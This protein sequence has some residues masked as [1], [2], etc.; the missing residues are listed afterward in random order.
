MST[1]LKYENGVK[2]FLMHS[3]LLY[4]STTIFFILVTWLVFIHIYILYLLIIRTYSFLYHF[5]Y[6]VT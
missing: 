2:I 5:L 6:I 1:I 4:P 3:Q